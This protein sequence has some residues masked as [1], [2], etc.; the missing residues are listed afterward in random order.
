[1]GVPR[2]NLG[3]FL[4]EKKNNSGSTSVQIISKSSGKYK[5]V[6]TI[7]SCFNEQDLQKLIYLGKQEI[8]RLSNQPKLFISENDVIV[9]QVFSSLQNSSIKTIGPE[10]I[11]GAIFDSIGFNSLQEDLFRHL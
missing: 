9:D 10:I 8:E 6:K 2:L 11:F 1:M 7:G 3:V 4:R 5:V